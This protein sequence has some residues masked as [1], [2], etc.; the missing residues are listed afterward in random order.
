[1][2]L[3]SKAIRNAAVAASFAHL[4]VWPDMAETIAFRPCQEKV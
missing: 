2:A 3:L 1:L 4:I